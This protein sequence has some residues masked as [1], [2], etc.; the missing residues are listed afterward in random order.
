MDRDKSCA[1]KSWMYGSWYLFIENCSQMIKRNFYLLLLIRRAFWRNSFRPILEAI[2]HPHV[3]YKRG[4]QVNISG[5]ISK[6]DNYCSLGGAYCSLWISLP[7][8]F[9]TLS[10]AIEHAKMGDK[11]PF[12]RN[13]IK[14][15]AV[16]HL[17]S[18]W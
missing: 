5:F 2:C 14:S 18:V 8:P 10:F 6:V 7:Y 1:P 15:T 4:K 9:T 16:S 13:E 11:E 3:C 17:V 12:C